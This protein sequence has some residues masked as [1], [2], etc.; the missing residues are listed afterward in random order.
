MRFKEHYGGDFPL[1]NLRNNALMSSKVR[2][3]SLNTHQT[4]TMW[5][6]MK[7]Q[8][9]LKDAPEVVM[10]TL[11]HT[12]ASDLVNKGVSIYVIKELLGHSS[13]DVTNIYT[14]VSNRTLHDAVNL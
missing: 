5:K 13:V 6:R 10:H 2:L 1:I 9:K 12:F 3:I 8:S 11:R 7:S 4:D 14:H